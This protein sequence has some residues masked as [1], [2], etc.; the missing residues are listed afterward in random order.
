MNSQMSILMVT[1]GKECS[2]RML[3]DV[4]KVCS[5]CSVHNPMNLCTKF[6]K[7]RTRNG[8]AIVN[9]ILKVSYIGSKLTRM[10]VYYFRCYWP[11]NLVFIVRCVTYVPNLRNIGQKP[12]SL[13][14]TIGILDRHTHR[15]TDRQ[16][17]RHALK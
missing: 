17:A 15:Q 13:F 1:V 5:R 16:T 11:S 9:T 7:N 8:S 3:Q 14:W 6:D 10:C 4:G 2:R 12:R